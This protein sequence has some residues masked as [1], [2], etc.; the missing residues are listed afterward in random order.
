MAYEEHQG[1][2]HSYIFWF[3]FAR[4]EDLCFWLKTALESAILTIPWRKD[5]NVKSFL[6]FWVLVRSGDF[7]TNVSLKDYK[8]ALYLNEFHNIKNRK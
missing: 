6:F 2:I 1:K 3:S 5:G 4:N 8:K 7:Y